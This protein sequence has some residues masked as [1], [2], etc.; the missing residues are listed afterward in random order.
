MSMA[1]D[2]KKKRSRSEDGRSPRAAGEDLG[3]RS[4]YLLFYQIEKVG[5]K[6]GHVLHSASITR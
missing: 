1:S 4:L 6:W 3:M 2:K 5:M